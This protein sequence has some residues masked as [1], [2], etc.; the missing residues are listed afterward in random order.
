MDWLPYPHRRVVL[1]VFSIILSCLPAASALASGDDRPD[2]AGLASGGR[3]YDNWWVEAG[4]D[5][6]TGTHPSYPRSGKASGASTWRCKECHGWDY[7]GRDGAY[8]NGSHRTGIKGIRAYDGKS[9]ESVRAILKGGQHGYG[10][11][12]EDASLERL[13]RFVVHGQ[14]E[15]DRYIDRKSKDARG[16]AAKGK[17][18]FR[19]YCTRCHGDDG[20]QLNFKAASGGVEYLGTIANENPWEALHKIINGHPGAIIG[21]EE[22]H[23]G[24]MMM[25]HQR[26]DGPYMG[27]RMP[28]LRG[29]VSLSGMADLLKYLQ[30]LPSK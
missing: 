17:T 13:A 27:E 6:P 3:L 23:S 20:R 22:M 21:H 19:K 14:V 7:M 9:V 26:G 24:G 15:M 5:K 25:H 12:M 30:T 4:V 1:L 29:R 28:S 16:T 18:L 10:K 11:L 2:K 8:A